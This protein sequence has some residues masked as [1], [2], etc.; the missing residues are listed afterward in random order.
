MHCPI[1]GI[2]IPRYVLTTVT[3]FIF[4]FATDYLIHGTIL[5]DIYAE[6]AELWR[7]ESDMKTYL[8]FM[9]AGQ[10]LIAAITAFIF[11]RNYEGKG[12]QE[13]VRFG[14]L[15]GLLFSVMMSI[16]YVWLPISLLLAIYWACAGLMQGLG[17]GIIFSLTYRK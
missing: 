4:L 10:F 11:T 8:P 5:K 6:T 15:L 17:L 2:N 7:P 3:G 1:C 9:L 16:S 14:I 13:G 12:F